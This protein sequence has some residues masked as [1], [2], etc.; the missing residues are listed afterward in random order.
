MHIYYPESVDSLAFVS[1]VQTCKQCL[2][3]YNENP[4]M[5][6]QR[7]SKTSLL[8]KDPQNRLSSPQRSWDQSTSYVAIYYRAGTM[9][10]LSACVRLGSGVRG[11]GRHQ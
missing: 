4:E 8:R 3:L 11:P 2:T 7:C 10:Y 6:Q 5:D 1:N 9:N